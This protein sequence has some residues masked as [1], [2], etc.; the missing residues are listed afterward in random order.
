MTFSPVVASL[1][2]F[3]FSFPEAFGCK[4]DTRGVQ[5]PTGEKAAGETLAFNLGVGPHTRERE[6]ER[7]GP[8]GTSKRGQGDAHGC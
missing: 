2:S 4:R 3:F 5:G 8:G 1:Q 7:S 6:R